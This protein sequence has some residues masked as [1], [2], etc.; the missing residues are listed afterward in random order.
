M[1]ATSST[2]ITL[3]KKIGK[4][5][6]WSIGTSGPVVLILVLIMVATMAVTT[7]KK[8]AIG[9]VG[10]L[11]GK[12]PA[13]YIDDFDYTSRVSGIGNWVLAAVCKQ[14]SAF[15]MDV[16]SAAGTY[17]LMQF[18]K[19]END[20]TSNWDYYLNK[21]LDQWFKDAGYSYSNSEEAWEIFLKDSKMQILAG[22]FSLMEKGNYALKACGIVDTIQPF[23]E[24]GR[25]HV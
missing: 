21:G 24:I 2:E 14:E 18:R 6:L 10:N 17:G 9:G 7:N 1:E 22:S 25:A 20:G 3:V 8:T 19:Y 13:K 12:V 5:A 15:R 11:E 23:N 4:Y 16:V